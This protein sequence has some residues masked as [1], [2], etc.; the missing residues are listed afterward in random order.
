MIDLGELFSIYKSSEVDEFITQLCGSTLK[1]RGLSENVIKDKWRFVGDNPSNSSVINILKSPDKGIIERLTNGIDAV[2][3]REKLEHNISMPKCAEDIVKIVYPKYYENNRQIKRGT[4]ESSHAYEALD[5][6]IL[7]INDGSTSAKPT[8]DIIDKGTGLNGADF[9]NTIL[10][11]NKG[12]K[13]SS[14][15]EYLIGAFGQGGSTS[16]SHSY[17]TIIVSKKAGRYYCTIVKGV[18][19]KEYKTQAF[20]YYVEDGEVPEGFISENIEFHDDQVAQFLL[21]DSGT[22]VRMIETDVSRKYRVNDITKPGMLGDY[23]NTEL[24]NVALPV[25][26]VENRKNYSQNKNAQNR[27]SFGS[28]A[29]LCTWKYSKKEYSGSLTIDHKNNSYKVDYYVVLPEDESDWGKDAK[30]KETYQRFNTSLD[31]IIYTVNGQ[32]VTSELFTKLR[33]A[34]LNFLQYR[35]LVVVDLDILG[36]EKYQFFTTDRSSLKKS[37]LANGFVDSIVDALSKDQ[38]LMGINQRVA[39]KSLSANIDNDLLKEISKEV[40]S[41]YQNF[42]AGGYVRL[43]GHTGIPLHENEEVYLDHIEGIKITSVKDKFYSNEDVKVILSTG[44]M[45]SVNENAE[46]F[47]Y[48]DGRASYS[49]MKTCFNGRIQFIFSSKDIGVGFHEILFSFYENS[50][51]VSTT[52][53]FPFEVVDS[54]SDEPARAVRMDLDLNIFQV[55][56]QELIVSVSKNLERKKIDIYLCLQHD[57]LAPVYGKKANS[58]TVNTIKARLIKPVTMYA[59]LLDSIYEDLESVDKKNKMMAAFAQSIIASAQVN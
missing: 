49:L 9:P 11:I 33:N 2:L 53:S 24:F 28:L 40:K 1:E 27:N 17:A 55:D 4:K 29:K 31:P 12:N 48:I 34:S 37:D 26:M 35:L 41:Y 54:V 36:N 22:F 10:S 59:L 30:C 42:L 38:I 58:D 44:A 6:V 16:L 39:E 43:A 50:I 7:S 47:A 20:M 15:K 21:A 56:N 13:L 8:I 52:P 46:I 18:Q 14:D 57:M 32:F 25:K 3:E 45:K 51:E 19:L 5:K 23:V